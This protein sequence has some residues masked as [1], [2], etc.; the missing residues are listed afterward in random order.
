MALAKAK[1]QK[2]PI[3]INILILFKIQ[4]IILFLLQIKL[5]SDKEKI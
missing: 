1:I 5:S 2:K 4:G 3:S